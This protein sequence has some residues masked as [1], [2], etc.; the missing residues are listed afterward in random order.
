MQDGERRGSTRSQA[1]PRTATDRPPTARRTDSDHKI[2]F[3]TP[4]RMLTISRRRSRRGRWPSRP[5]RTVPR[6]RARRGVWRRRR[7]RRDHSPS[8]IRVPRAR[9]SRRRCRRRRPEGVAAWRPAAPVRESPRLPASSFDPDGAGT[10]SV[11]GDLR[12]AAPKPSVILRLG[13]GRSRRTSIE[14]QVA[15]STRRAGSCRFW[16]RST[17]SAAAA[18]SGSGWSIWSPWWQRHAG[19]HRV[20][21]PLITAGCARFLEIE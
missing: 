19:C 17:G 5:R 9:T 4:R 1:V 20:P 12:R 2:P 13:P 14:Q 3:S 6:C 15:R 18:V 11:Y 10:A 16:C 21:A 7:A 8:A